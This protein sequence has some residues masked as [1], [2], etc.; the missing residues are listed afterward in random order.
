MKRP[1]GSFLGEEADLITDLGL[2]GAA[3]ES[4]AETRVRYRSPPSAD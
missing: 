4:D 1:S 2:I 3:V